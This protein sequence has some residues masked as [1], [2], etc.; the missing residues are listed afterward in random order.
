MLKGCEELGFFAHLR[1]D[2]HA[3]TGERRRDEGARRDVD[4]AEYGVEDILRAHV[5]VEVVCENAVGRGLREDVDVGDSKVSGACETHY[6][7]KL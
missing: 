1:V 7:D 6:L 2:H 3:T 4:H 5:Q